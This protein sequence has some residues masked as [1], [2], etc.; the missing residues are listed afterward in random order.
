MRVASSPGLIVQA[1]EPGQLATGNAQPSCGK[2]GSLSAI[3]A[4]DGPHGLAIFWWR[5]DAGQRWVRNDALPQIERLAATQNIDPA[6]RLARRAMD[7]AP[8]DPQLKQMW[9]NLTFRLLVESDP[10]GAMVSF[11]TYANPDTPWIS[12]GTTPTA[13]VNVP[14]AQIRFRLT[15]DGYAPIEAAPQL[16]AT[17]RFKLRRSGDLQQRMVAVPGGPTNFEGRAVE[18]S[19]F[20]IDQFEVTNREYKRLAGATTGRELFYC[21]E[22]DYRSVD[23]TTPIPSRRFS[24][25]TRRSNTTC[26]RTASACCSRGPRTTSP[27][28]R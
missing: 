19:D 18:I 9:E 27:W 24:F 15:K 6:Y 4:Y 10:P 17:M 5:Q 14:M 12:I 13:S 28:S 3:G 2:V 11:K 22:L 23:M 8:D 1:N 7:V 16:A 20:Q 21:T 25:E 26:P